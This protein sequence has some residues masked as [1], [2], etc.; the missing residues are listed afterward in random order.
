MDHTWTTIVLL[1]AVSLLF[2]TKF[3]RKSS[4]LPPTIFPTIPIIGHLH[5]LKKPLHRTLSTLSEKHGPILLLCF[6]SRNVLLVSSPISKQCFTENDVVFADRPRLL[7]G[8]ILGSNYTSLGFAPYGNHWRNLRRISNTEIFSSNRINEFRDTRANEGRFLVRKLISESSS[9]VNLT[10]VFH[11]MIWN[12]MM[13]ILS[14]KRFFGGCVDLEEGK[15]FKELANET[16]LVFGATN[17]GDHLPILRW[18]GVKGFENKLI[19][20]QKKRNEFIQG[21]IHQIRIAKEEKIENDSMMEKM[22]KNTVVDVLLKLQETDPVFYTDEV[23]RSLVLN[24]L[25]AGTDTSTTTME[26]A[27]SLLLNHPHILTKARAEIDNQVGKSRLIDES[28]I[29]NLPYLVCIVKETLRMYPPGPLLL[30]HEPSKDCVVE[31]YHIPRGT[32]LLVN[33]WDIQQQQQQ[34]QNPIPYDQDV[35]KVSVHS[36]GNNSNEYESDNGKEINKQSSALK[37]NSVFKDKKDFSKLSND[38]GKGPIVE[39]VILMNDGQSPSPIKDGKPTYLK[40]LFKEMVDNTHAVKKVHFRFMEPIEEEE[41]G[42]G[43]MI[44]ISSS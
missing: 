23:I 20:L 16:F 18:L 12:V 7:V 27:F 21:L 5:L 35:D 32:M 10:S 40:P 31:G 28:D 15:R 11:E 14:G 4:N 22:M 44:H 19:E 26:W 6:G 2:V 8:K 13:T 3:R 9:P 37:S 39:H 17:L 1:F 42:V 29:I 36:V 34:Q 38:D 30:P 24:L 43:V 25:D 33:Q 41:Q